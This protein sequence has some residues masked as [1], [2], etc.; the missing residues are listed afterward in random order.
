MSNT[1]FRE[2]KWENL[3]MIRVCLH[4]FL[5]IIFFKWECTFLKCLKKLVT[6]W[7]KHIFCGQYNARSSLKECWY[8]LLINFY[9]LPKV[10]KGNMQSELSNWELDV[11]IF[12]FFCSPFV[13]RNP[14]IMFVLWFFK[15][16]KKV[17]FIFSIWVYCL[18]V[19]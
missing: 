8:F 4:L 13:H 7:E 17:L 2:G 10:T 12:S 16:F 9:Q 1:G 18:H 15:T 5:W 6:L 19:R 3:I 11:Q 14:S